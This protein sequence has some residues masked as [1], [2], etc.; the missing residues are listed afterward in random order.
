[1]DNIGVVDKTILEFEKSVFETPD[2]GRKWMDDYLKKV[3]N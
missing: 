3:L 1:M 2:L